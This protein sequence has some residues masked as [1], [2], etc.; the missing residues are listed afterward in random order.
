MLQNLSIA[1]LLRGKYNIDN[2]MTVTFLK[3]FMAKYDIFKVKYRKSI[4]NV[5]C[6][7]VLWINV[8]FDLAEPLIMGI[9][10][11]Y[12]RNDSSPTKGIDTIR[13]H[14]PQGQ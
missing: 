8:K 11:G 10:R 3:Y 2:T 6:Q 9:R 1:F 5:F 12:R 14:I 13:S 4:K 7:N